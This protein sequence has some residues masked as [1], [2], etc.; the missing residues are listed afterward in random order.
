MIPYD[1]TLLSKALPMI[2]ARKKPLRPAEFLKS[3]DID[4]KLSSKVASVN[5]TSK[6]ITLESGEVLSYDKLCISTGSKARQPTMP[7]ASLKGVHVLRTS[8]D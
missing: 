6:M 4:Y 3:A 8:A 1:R 2:D 5:K 7:G